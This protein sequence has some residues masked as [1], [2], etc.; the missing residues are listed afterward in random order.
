MRNATK[1][2]R[3]CG[4]EYEACKPS[5]SGSVSRW[6]DVACCVEHGAEYFDR[7]AKS[8][9]VQTVAS[10]TVESATDENETKFEDAPADGAADEAEV[11]VSK[12][13]RKRRV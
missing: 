4:K 1:I 3:I 13:K 9:G 5:F 12:K 7:I 6:Q 2:C 11:P 8:R 10:T